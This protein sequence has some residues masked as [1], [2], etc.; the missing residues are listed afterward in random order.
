MIHDTFGVH[1][2][3]RRH[4]TDYKSDLIGT[5]YLL[6]IGMGFIVRIA[7]YSSPLRPQLKSQ[8]EALHIAFRSKMYFTLTTK[9]LLNKSKNIRKG[10]R[11]RQERPRI[12]DFTFTYTE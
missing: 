10:K 9:V 4:R 5:W 1:I 11:Q 3:H 6:E 2:I 12:T 8:D 7:S